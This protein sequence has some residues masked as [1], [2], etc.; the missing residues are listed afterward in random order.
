[1]A[2][3]SPVR[4]C[5]GWICRMLHG[6]RNALDRPEVSLFREIRLKNTGSIPQGDLA[7]GRVTA[8]RHVSALRGLGIGV[9]SIDLSAVRRGQSDGG[10][11]EGRFRHVE[12]GQRLVR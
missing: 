12:P 11:A 10:S 9:G 5:G 3:P 6:A 2:N 8:P 1:T 7:Y 4:G